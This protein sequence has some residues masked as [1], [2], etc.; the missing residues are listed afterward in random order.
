MNA[1]VSKAWWLFSNFRRGTRVPFYLMQQERSQWYP[2]EK[3]KRLQWA[4]LNRLLNHAHKN[5][6]YYR[7]LFCDLNLNPSDIKGLEDLQRLPVLTK[8]ELQN[9][10]ESLKARNF[11]KHEF[12]MNSSGGST[13]EP[14]FFYHHKEKVAKQEAAVLRHDRWAGW[15]VGKRKACLWGAR[16]DTK[17][18]QG[19]RK[20]VKE[21]FMNRNLVLDA[22][23]MSQQKMLVYAKEL[24]DLRPHIILAYTSAIY[25]FAYFLN[26]NNIGGIRPEAIIASAETLYPHQRELIESTLKC[27]IFNRYGGREVGIIASECSGHNGLHINAENLIVEVI[28]EGKPA[29]RGQ[30]GDIIVTDLT[31]YAMPFIRYNTDDLGV[32]SNRQCKCGRGLPLLEKVV[33]RQV[34][35]FRTKD[36]GVVTPEFFIHYVG[37]VFNKGYISNL[38][39]IQKALDHII[40]RVVVKDQE[41]FNKYKGK[42]E[43]SIRDV[44]GPD[45]RIDWKFIDK[46][47]PSPSGKFR[48][49][50]S[51]VAIL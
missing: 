41:L 49:T 15:R 14:V 25:S 17:P 38:Q 20:K 7:K 10:L 3:L 33:G 2:P 12:F 42:I 46:I 1:K 23:D 43:A 51:E 9:N 47:P 48:Y 22:F 40:I 34:D 13:G 37:V 39:I 35:V 21:F 18:N 16:R 36:G 5:V 19:L 6:P 29:K 45:C 26:E 32:L 24:K 50:I 30:P 8:R 31:N 28:K 27:P 4:K 44:M 11:K